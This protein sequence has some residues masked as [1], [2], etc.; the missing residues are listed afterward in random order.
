MAWENIILP[1][2]CPYNDHELGLPEGIVWENDYVQ[3]KKV[4][5]EDFEVKNAEGFIIKATYYYTGT[6]SP[7][8]PC[9]IYLH[10]KGGCRIE[11]KTIKQV[12]FEK[13]NLSLCT[14]DFPGNGKS[15]GTYVTLGIKETDDT[16]L[17]INFLKKTYQIGKKKYFNL[18]IK[19][20]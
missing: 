6:K 14:F 11:I 7:G 5:R 18:K 12:L 10:A 4:K 20:N 13:G 19:A 2:R 3:Q 16:N 8:K 15:E 17:I 1:L 9:V